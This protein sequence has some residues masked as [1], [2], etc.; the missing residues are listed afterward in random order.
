M[1][2]IILLLAVV[3]ATNTKFCF[4]GKRNPKSHLKLSLDYTDPVMITITKLFSF[5]S[6]YASV[7]K[8]YENIYPSIN[9][10]KKVSL[11]TRQTFAETK[12][13]QREIGDNTGKKYESDMKFEGDIGGI[14]FFIYFGNIARNSYNFQLVLRDKEKNM[15][16]YSQT[17]LAPDVLQKKLLILHRDDADFEYEICL[18]M[19]VF[20][21][22]FV[23]KN[24]LGTEKISDILE[25]GKN[26]GCIPTEIEFQES[27]REDYQEE[28]LKNLLLKLQEEHSQ[29][30][31]INLKSKTSVNNEAQ[32]STT[33]TVTVENY[34]PVNIIDQGK[35]LV[36]Q[37][38]EE[39]S[40][41]NEEDL[42]KRLNFKSKIP[43]LNKIRES[44]IPT[45][46]KG[47]Y[48]P[49]N[50]GKSKIP[51]L[52][53]KPLKPEQIEQK[54]DEF[55]ERPIKERPMKIMPEQIERKKDELEERPIKERP[56]E[57]QIL[58]SS[59]EEENLKII[60]TPELSLEKINEIQQVENKLLKPTDAE[61]NFDYS[62]IENYD[63]IKNTN[64]LITMKV[65]RKIT[66]F[67]SDLA[68]MRKDGIFEQNDPTKKV[69]FFFDKNFKKGSNSLDKSKIVH[70]G[71]IEPN[72]DILNQI[73]NSGTE[74]EK[75][76]LEKNLNV[77]MRK[78]LFFLTFLKFL[79]DNLGILPSDFQFKVY[80]DLST[81][82]IEYDTA[83][84]YKFEEPILY[85]YLKKTRYERILVKVQ[86]TYQKLYFRKNINFKIEYLIDEN[87]ENCI[88]SIPDVKF[89]SNLTEDQ[90]E[91]ILDRVKQIYLENGKINE[92][93]VVKLGQ[94]PVDAEDIVKRIV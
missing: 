37:T 41:S 62:K 19:I 24:N 11:S 92:N 23:T 60:K 16:S 1:P 22:K 77:F 9:L 12:N 74:E 82:I 88:V 8:V 28:R 81:N 15:E 31:N 73:H 42:K 18:N 70:P 44:K 55:E 57:R 45:T 34:E 83:V 79:Q 54:K 14:P 4:C 80:E 52:T 61:K 17:L 2:K 86:E 5:V 87:K 91:S 46:H 56:M 43:V 30:Q 25:D 3:T 67:T 26:G 27:F 21:N 75:Q 59:S 68:D 47:I 69:I 58:A 38:G 6:K 33:K 50:T 36:E 40:E 72:D 93:T 7:N 64:K 39:E 78:W 65:E 35:I 71:N 20:V 63:N 53:K 51:I 32:R 84:L 89:V 10:D 66:H 85:Q 76:E 13:G 29:T 94:K 90:V 49:L 48:K